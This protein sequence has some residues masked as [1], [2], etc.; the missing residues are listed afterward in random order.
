MSKQKGP[1][2]ARSPLAN[3]WTALKI[4]PPTE[5]TLR[6]AGGD[7]DI[8]KGYQ[9]ELWVLKVSCCSASFIVRLLRD[10]RFSTSERESRQ[11]TRCGPWGQSAAGP[12]NPGGLWDCLR[13][14]NSKFP[15]V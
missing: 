9:K 12:L 4:D 13:I 5:I 11:A 14:W 8:C 15:Q 1:Q 2:I 6:R 7:S 3:Q 10:R